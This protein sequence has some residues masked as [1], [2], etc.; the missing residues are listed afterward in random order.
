MFDPGLIFPPRHDCEVQP[1]IHKIQLQYLFLYYLKIYFS[2]HN[3]KEG[4]AKL[5]LNI[6]NVKI[7][8]GR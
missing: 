5:I 7:S 8:Q 2:L 1:G 4:Q 3:A 6:R